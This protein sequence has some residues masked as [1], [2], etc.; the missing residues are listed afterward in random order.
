MK[1]LNIIEGK[2]SCRATFLIA[3]VLEKVYLNGI[4]K[5]FDR[6]RPTQVQRSAVIEYLTAYDEPLSP[7]VGGDFP[8]GYLESTLAAGGVT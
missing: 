6:Y 1:N 3:S 5:I 8:D 4:T 7:E 2:Q